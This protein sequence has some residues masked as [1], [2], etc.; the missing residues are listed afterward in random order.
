MNCPTKSCHKRTAARTVAADPS[1]APRRG[2]ASLESCSGGSAEVAQ[3]PGSVHGC[4]GSESGFP[5]PRNND[6][7]WRLLHPASSRVPVGSFRSE[8]PQERRQVCLLI[9]G[10]LGAE[11]L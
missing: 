2:K 3:E 10:E 1:G 8:R 4:W 5:G 11:H 9:R 7:G 6:A